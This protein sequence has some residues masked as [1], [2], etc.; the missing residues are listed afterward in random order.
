MPRTAKYVEWEARQ[1]GVWCSAGQ[2]NRDSSMGA[3]MV[4]IRAILVQGLG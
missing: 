2:E 4:N 3:E 1:I